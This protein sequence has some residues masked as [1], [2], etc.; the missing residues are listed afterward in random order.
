MSTKSNEAH[1][2][3]MCEHLLTV[4]RFLAS[5]HTH[6]A[7]YVSSAFKAC[8][9]YLTSVTRAGFKGGQTGAV[10]PAPP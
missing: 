10:A 1:N 6:R 3:K 8:C 9:G 7:K 2:V 4:S 5:G